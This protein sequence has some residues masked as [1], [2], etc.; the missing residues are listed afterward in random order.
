MAPPTVDQVKVT[1]AVALA[2]AA[3][4]RSVGGVVEHASIG[5]LIAPFEAQPLASSRVTAMETKPDPPA[6]KVIEEVPCPAVIVPLKRAHVNVPESPP[7]TVAVLPVEKAMTEVGART[8]SAGP[9]VPTL[10]VWL[11]EIEQPALAGRDVDKGK[12]RAL[13]PDQARLGADRPGVSQRVAVARQQQ[14]VAVVDGEIGR[15]VEIGT[16][17]A[18][19]LLRRLVDMHLQAGIAQPHGRGKAGNPGADDVDGLGHQMKA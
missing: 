16:A 13:R 8:V 1:G 3:G 10:T 4:E 19:G 2:P 9:P 6:V 7:R 14:M 5:T 12:L 15:S 17:A 18:A 11:S